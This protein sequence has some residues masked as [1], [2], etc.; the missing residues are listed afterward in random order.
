MP[1]FAKS[2]V[3]VKEPRISLNIRLRPETHTLLQELVVRTGLRK[4]DVIHFAIHSLAEGDFIRD[5]DP[6]K[7]RY[8]PET[9]TWTPPRPERKKQA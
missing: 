1:T 2:E 8:D 5:A 6:E 4:T 9:D 3:S 7:P